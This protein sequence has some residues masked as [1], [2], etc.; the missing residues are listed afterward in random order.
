MSD[1]RTRLIKLIH[2]G[3]RELL[4]SDD[5]YRGILEAVTGKD[6]S[7]ACN[8]RQLDMVLAALK[9][10][11]FKPK[12]KASVAK[13]KRMSPASTGD[14]VDKLR[15]VWITMAQQGFV[16]DGSET[17]LDSYVNRM[18]KTRKMGAVTSAAFMTG[19]QAAAVLEELKMWH[20][21]LMVDAMKANGEA[22]DT[23]LPGYD[24]I[25]KGYARLMKM[26]GQQ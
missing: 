21:R 3:R 11:G 2:V 26:K 10:H 22:F 7:S 5:Q 1:N 18:L 25:C 20:R 12:S 16:R 24:A 4:L 6:T 19:N 14:I 15:A 8:E 17:A 23:K 9:R 13:G